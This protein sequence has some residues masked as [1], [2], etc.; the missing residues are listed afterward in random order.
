[1]PA[2][3]HHLCQASQRAYISR[4]LR[5]TAMEVLIYFTNIDTVA[6]IR[7][8]SVDLNAMAAIKRWTV[9]IEDCDK[10]LRIEASADLSEQIEDTLARNGYAWRVPA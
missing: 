1:M 6:D 10:V 5:K 3:A 2:A 4:P 8:V 9:D 7:T